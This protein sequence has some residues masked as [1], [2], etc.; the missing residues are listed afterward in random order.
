LAGGVGVARAATERQAASTSEE[1][2]G[3]LV[4]AHGDT[5]HGTPSVMQTDVR[6]S[7]GLVPVLLSGS[8]NARAMQ[9]SGHSVRL[10]G[11]RRGAAF[12]ATSIDGASANAGGA[13]LPP[14]QYGNPALVNPGEPAPKVMHVAVLLM[15]APG[16][17][18]VFMPTAASAQNSFFGATNSFAGYIKQTSGGQT[19]VTGKV[20]GYYTPPAS[21]KNDCDLSDW[22]G[23]GETAAAADGFNAA[24]YAYPVV[25]SAYQNCSFAGIA[26]VGLGDAWLNGAVDNHNHI[27]LSIAAHE[28]GHNLS[29]GHAGSYSCYPDQPFTYTGSACIFEDYG[30]GLDVMGAASVEN[31]YQYNGPHKAML[32][33]IPPAEI[34]T[35]SSG[36]QTIALTANENPLVAGSTELIN[37]PR[38][39]GSYLAVDRREPSGYDSGLNDLAGVYVHLVEDV[40]SSDT[41]TVAWGL[42]PGSSF[43]DPST[44]ITVTTVTD[45][46]S[47]AT[48][49]IQVCG[50]GCHGG[51]GPTTTTSTSTASTSTT[52]TSTTT[53]LPHTP[54]AVSVSVVNG[55]IEVTGSS[56]DDVVHLTEVHDNVKSIDANGAPV[57]AGH[58]CTMSAP[59]V[60]PTAICHGASFRAAMGDGNDTVFVNG[61]MGSRS[62][63]DGGAGD[64][65]FVPGYGPETFIGGDGDDTVDFTGR[66]PGSVTATI[67]GGA[68]SGAKRDH[69]D[70][71][72]DI[73]H[74]LLP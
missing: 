71:R 40:N 31:A 70:I 20:F 56:G 23:A 34:K 2:D 42:K 7:H 66:P 32:G 44:G 8:Q 45:D 51:G 12:A 50:L 24:D 72:S 27:I 26:G 48:A 5:F 57:V 19:T 37:V 22:I 3:T 25:V 52:S 39:D 6:T 11:V 10:H 46:P 63:L 17:G 47:A 43:T 61:T 9:L 41:E 59:A 54:D 38:G 13:V 62:I 55:K 73:E 4:V 28:L 18:G 1:L 21:L 69:D 58:G 35:V 29:F 33:W 64:D 65:T 49:S 60:V 53:T 74:V 16:G 68:H 14:S 36:T 67:G 15:R 30:D